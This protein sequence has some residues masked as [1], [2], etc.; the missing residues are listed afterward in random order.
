MAAAGGS[1]SWAISLRRSLDALGD[2]LLEDPRRRR[3]D[4]RDGRRSLVGGSKSVT[5]T[6]GDDA[7]RCPACDVRDVVA[8]RDSGGRELLL[9]RCQ[10]SMRRLEM[11]TSACREGAESHTWAEAK[12]CSKCEYE[13]NKKGKK[14]IEKNAV[15]ARRE[16][17]MANGSM[18]RKT[19]AK[20]KDPKLRCVAR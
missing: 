1:G 8:E 16:R 12:K 18:E 10:S 6:T 3:L 13:P 11:K 2:E 4:K 7:A 19:T 9:I 15:R 5:C 17:K 20:D 14:K